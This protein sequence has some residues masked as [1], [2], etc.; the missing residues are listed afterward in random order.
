MTGVAGLCST[1]RISAIALLTT[2]QEL[3][4]RSA[5]STRRF[6]L[7]CTVVT[8]DNVLGWCSQSRSRI[9]TLQDGSCGEESVTRKERWMIEVDV[10]VDKLSRKVYSR[11][12]KSFLEIVVKGKQTQVAK[13]L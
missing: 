13:A 2:V 11:A 5:P 9:S 6:L 8:I 4:G 7:R 10:R 3:N 1:V 12:A